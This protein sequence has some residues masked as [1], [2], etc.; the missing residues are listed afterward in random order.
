MLTCIRR[1][2]LPKRI[3]RKVIISWGIQ[4]GSGSREG[5]ILFVAVDD[6]KEYEYSISAYGGVVD[7]SS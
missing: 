3:L 6:V 1:G 2:R 4:D 7:D 5:G